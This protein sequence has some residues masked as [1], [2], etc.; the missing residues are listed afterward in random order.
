LFSHLFEFLFFLFQIGHFLKE[1][2]DV[3]GGQLSS[4]FKP[5]FVL[6]EKIGVV[7]GFVFSS[8]FVGRT[9]N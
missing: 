1:E 8:S 3:G 4:S 6:K 7:Q 5:S 2:E 9:T